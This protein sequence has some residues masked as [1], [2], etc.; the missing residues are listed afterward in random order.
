MLDLRHFEFITFDCY[1]T[2]ID[3]ESGILDALRPFRNEHGIR[4]SDDDILARYAALESDLENGAYM[5]YRDVLRGVMRGLAAH[6]AIAGASYDVDAIANS[7]PRWQPFPDTVAALRRLHERVRLGVISNTDDD[8][9]ARTAAH[10]EVEFDH[11][12][13][14]EQVKSY[15]PSPRNFLHAL[16]A[17][18]LPRERVLHAAQSRFHD[19]APAHALGIAT[20]WVNRRSGC[21]GEGATPVSGAMP[22]LEVPDL[23]T[24]AERVEASS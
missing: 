2:L 4:A 15:K 3:W 6:Y 7:L 10:L 18:G 14:A 23:N 12:T 16:D 1:G 21:G 19:V 13:T 8:L 17:I 11:V 20:V 22:D 9:F 24:L 5:R